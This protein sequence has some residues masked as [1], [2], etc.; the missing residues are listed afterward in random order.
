M[1]RRERR[2][3]SSQGRKGVEEV[4]RRGNVTVVLRGLREHM[5]RTSVD[6]AEGCWRVT[7]FDAADACCCVVDS[8]DASYA[9]AVDSADA[10]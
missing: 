2:R 8:A 4:V 7:H 10:S 6:S 1:W 5:L 3:L 9:Y